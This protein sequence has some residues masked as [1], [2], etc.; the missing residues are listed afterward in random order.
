MRDIDAYNIALSAAPEM[1]EAERQYALTVARGESGYGNWKPSQKTIEISQKFGL[2]GFEGVGSNNWGAVQGKGSAGSFPH[3]DHHAD[4]K[5]YVAQYQK[6]LTPEEGF[7][8]TART[9]YGGGKRG[10][11]G[12]EAI[13]SALA[14]GSL[15]EAVFAQ[16]ANG[17]FE[18]NPE[19]YLEA[20]LRN[21]AALTGNAGLSRILTES[22]T[23]IGLT[24]GS[25]ATSGT[26]GKV[27]GS[28]L[29][30]GAV[31]YAGYLVWDNW[32][33]RSK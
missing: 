12:A 24:L 11:L 14:K 26:A 32:K 18:L 10:A 15:R 22:G 28:L 20:V 19:K 1:S 21:Y 23:A 3:V 31:G 5:P 33:N 8:R 30:L 13:K 16:H 6:N 17:Y 7:L 4:G 27:I 29:L 25:G 9:L 2:T